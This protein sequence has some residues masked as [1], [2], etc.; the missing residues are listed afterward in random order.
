M[1][2][3]WKDIKDYEGLYQISSFGRVK[4]LYSKVNMG[5]ILKTRINNRGYCCVNLYKNSIMKSFMVHRLVAVTF[6]DNPDNKPCIDH[7]NTIKTDNSVS[8][9]RWVTHKE[10]SANKITKKHCS[11]WQK[12]KKKPYGYNE[13]GIYCNRSKIVICIELNKKFS[14][15][16]EAGRELNIC[17][18]SISKCCMGKY[19]IAGGY[20]WKFL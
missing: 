12:N 5:K 8:N 13:H 19:K 3:I 15:I 4:S 1:K 6:I 16:R 14:S 18:N 17:H 2:E 20:H 7:I 10:N 9:L 11:E